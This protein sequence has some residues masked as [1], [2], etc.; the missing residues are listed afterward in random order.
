MVRLSEH[1]FKVV[2]PHGQHECWAWEVDIDE[3]V[4]T[5]GR[6]GSDFVVCLMVGFSAARCR[7]LL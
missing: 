6:D 2:Q 4:M 5:R 3:L 7:V 1:A